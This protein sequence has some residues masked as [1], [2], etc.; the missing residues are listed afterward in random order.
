MHSGEQRYGL[1][2]FYCVQSQN[3]A[4]SILQSPIFSILSSCTP[5]L[6]CFQAQ[7]VQK[8]TSRINRDSGKQKPEI[9]M[10]FSHKSIKLLTT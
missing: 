5:D 10:H 9:L 8:R 7:E 6:L 4:Q 3:V 1:L 2:F